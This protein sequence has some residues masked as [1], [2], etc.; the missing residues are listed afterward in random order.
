MR[1]DDDKSEFTHEHRQT[2][3]CWVCRPTAVTYTFCLGNNI[4]LKAH[5][6]RPARWGSVSRH[7][8]HKLYS[9]NFAPLPI[10]FGHSNVFSY[11][12][13]KI[14]NVI[15]VW[16]SLS[17][18]LFCYSSYPKRLNAGLILISLVNRPVTDAIHH[19]RSTQR[20]SNWRF[21]RHQPDEPA[22]KRL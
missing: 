22:P 21:R 19:C 10:E 3:L 17:N 1:W 18:L 8:L 6:I 7:P 16:L 14:G 12:S 20:L 13:S 2:C 5:F 4:E 11:C 15:P 9:L